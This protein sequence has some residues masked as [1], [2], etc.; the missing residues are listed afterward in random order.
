M[1]FDAYM[2]ILKW[3]GQTSLASR[4]RV[5]YIFGNI[6]STLPDEVCNTLP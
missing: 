4:V 3:P 5:I 2:A 6:G 1:H